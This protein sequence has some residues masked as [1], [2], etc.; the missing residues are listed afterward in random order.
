MTTAETRSLPVALTDMPVPEWAAAIVVR[1]STRGFT[2][3]PVATPLLAKLETFVASFPRC[4]VARVV[5]VR[6]LP[7]EVF[8]GM[9]GGYVKVRGALSGLLVIGR[10]TETTCQES[11]GYLGEAALLAGTTMGLDTCWIGGFFDR[12]V[13]SKLVT[14]DRDERV[15]AVV[16]LGYGREEPPAGEKLFKRLMRAHKRR[17]IEEIAP[18]FD[19]KAWPAWAAEGVRLARVAPSALNR[20]PWQWRLE[21]ELAV[22]AIYAGPLEAVTISVLDRGIEGKISRRLDCGIAMLHFEVGA[23]LMGAVGR[24]KI[25]DGPDVARYRILVTGETV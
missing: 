14:L 7:S 21:S 2:G 25:L 17:P 4:D 22:A 20:Q 16:P 11:A 24:W 3:E 23:R 18:G 1:H 15:L 12:K 5:V 19:E 6:D 8:T 13:T 10:E 9:V